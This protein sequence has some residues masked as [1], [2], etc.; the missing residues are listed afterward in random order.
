MMCIM[1][2]NLKL[3][4]YVCYVPGPPS[5]PP[6]SLELPLA[7]TTNKKEGG[8]LG[9]GWFGLG[10]RRLSHSAFINKMLR[11]RSK[12]PAIPSVREVKNVELEDADKYIFI[13]VCKYI[14]QFSLNDESP[15]EES[16]EIIE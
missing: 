1:D 14:K 2:I 9:L 6:P 15:Y 16:K 12:S 3:R 10:G 11:V 13:L 8:I 4:E 7:P 5:S